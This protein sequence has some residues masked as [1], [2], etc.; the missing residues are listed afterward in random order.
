MHIILFDFVNPA[1][2]NEQQQPQQK[3]KVYTVA[4]EPTDGYHRY[5]R[6]A[7]HYGINVET[8][9][10]GKPWLGGNMNHLGGGYK[11]NLLRNALE[12]IKDDHEQLIIFTDSFDVIFMS[13]L[14]DIIKKFKNTGARILFSAERFCWP[15]PELHSHYP[16]V[17]DGQV[18]FLNSGMFIG[19]AND[20]YEIIDEKRLKDTDDDQLYYTRIYLDEAERTKHKIK[21]D[22]KSKIFQNLNG[23]TGEVKLE[24]DYQTGFAFI[25]NL[26]FQTRPNVLHGNGPTKMLLNSFG[27]YLAG[28]W[29]YDKCYICAESTIELKDDAALPLITMALFVEKPM[30]FLDEFFET[31]YTLDYPKDRLKVFVHNAIDYHSDVVQKWIEKYEKVYSSLKTILPVDNVAEADARNLAV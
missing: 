3:I 11:I 28:S 22:H 7:E 2:T 10:M 24:F 19:Y 27:N 1:E 20:V 17:T 23:A 12:S 30:P 13:E 18:R 15:E 9:G 14:D 16:P 5:I 21:L 8:L 4:S 31:I 26:E 25:T 6:S 29:T